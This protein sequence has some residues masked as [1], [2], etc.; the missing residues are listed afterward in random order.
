MMRAR[1]LALATL[2]A[3]G[4][5]LAPSAHGAPSVREVSILVHLD[6]ALAPATL[7]DGIRPL[8]EASTTGGAFNRMQTAMLARQATG[9]PWAVVLSGS[10]DGA[11]VNA[12]ARWV[13]TGG[14]GPSETT[15]RYYVVEDAPA[16]AST[17]RFVV[18]AT[19]NATSD[20]LVAHASVARD[21][22]WDSARIGIVALAVN[23]E[24]NSTRFAPGEVLQSGVWL[25]RQTEATEQVRKSVL[26]ERT[27]AT[28]CPACAP[29]D[30]ALA[31]LASQYGFPVG[32]TSAKSYQAGFPPLAW[33]GLA[34]GGLLGI[35]LTR[36]RP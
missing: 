32:S 14:P 9:T 31:L 20:G 24:E 34:V 8:E 2:L 10:V 6:A 30:E 16:D 11:F 1:L 4:L 13:P 23:A 15:F 29:G 33:A 17:P 26:I 27:T 22:S 28:S 5:L 21:P 3:V 19:M 35:A 25:A 12:T 7:V 18:R 36:W